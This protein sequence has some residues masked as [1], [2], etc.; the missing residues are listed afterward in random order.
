MEASAPENLDEY[1]SSSTTIIFDNPIPLLRGPIPAGKPDNPALGPYVL[2]FK[3]IAAWSAARKRCESR[4]IEQCE[5]GARIGCAISAS[6][7]C[8]PPWWRLNS[9]DLKERE[10]CEQREMEACLVAGKEKCVEFAKEKCFRPFMDARV[11]VRRMGARR[12]EV[13]RLVCLASM[14]E[15]STWRDLIC[16]DQ[17][18]S[19]FLGE[20][21]IGVMN[22]RASELLGSD[23]NYESEL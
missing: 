1:S 12:K 2:A 10:I 15:S 9:V 6:S 5:N 7:K 17:L 11:A 19:R 16:L 18:S 14:P 23:T 13:E 3:S 8:K 4:I 21:E 22:F 20:F